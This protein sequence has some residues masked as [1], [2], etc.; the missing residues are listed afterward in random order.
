MWLVGALLAGMG[1]NALAVPR[2]SRRPQA[3]A[4][5][6]CSA[7]VPAEAQ[8]FAFKADGAKLHWQA[9]ETQCLST[10][11]PHGVNTTGVILR[12]C[13]SST[14]WTRVAAPS[15]GIQ[16]IPMK[17]ICADGSPCPASGVC[18]D[19]GLFSLSPSTDASL[20][21]RA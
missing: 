12:T 11:I 17:E 7:M 14:N 5:R 18:G 20:C 1:A 3:A 8:R 6:N 15:G 21:L 19:N 10:T 2:E 4:L 13:A 16:C 9:D